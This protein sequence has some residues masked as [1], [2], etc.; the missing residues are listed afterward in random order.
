MVTAPPAGD[1]EVHDD[2]AP[3]GVRVE[4]RRLARQD[5]GRLQRREDRRA[6]RRL[7]RRGDRRAAPLLPVLRLLAESVDA[8]QD[9]R[10]TR[11]LAAPTPATGFPGYFFS[12]GYG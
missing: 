7:R 2:R 4:R 1:E 10:C 12:S 9:I 6:A 11:Q 3:A 8:G 5:A